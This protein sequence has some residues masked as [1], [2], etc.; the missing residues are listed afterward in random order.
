VKSW[1]FATQNKRE[2]TFAYRPR[3]APG[4]NPDEQVWN[5]A[6]ARLSKLFVENME[7]MKRSVLSILR[8]I[9]MRGDRIISSFQTESTRY[10]AL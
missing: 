4:L 6:T 5:H 1:R 9:Q 7:T 2:V 3:Y 10:A 8:S